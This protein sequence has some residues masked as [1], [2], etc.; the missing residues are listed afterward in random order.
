MADE[1]LA[2]WPLESKALAAALIKK[3]GAPAERT[4]HQLVWYGNGPWKRTVLYREEVPHNFPMK[5]EAVLE[6]AVHYKVP[7]AKFSEL[8]EYDGA[9]TASRLLGE[10]AVRTESEDSNLLTLNLA[11]DI[12]TG[13]RN[14]QQALAY[15]AQVIRGKMTGD[16]GVYLEKL[17]FTPPTTSAET[18]DP[19]EVAP[20]IRHMA[21]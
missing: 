21:E 7:V 11:H 4:A 14:V 15:H 8:A 3:Y 13:E 16:R 5:H 1:S 9:I 12:V 10:I 19:G 6:Q 2:G 17:K 20:L 18:A